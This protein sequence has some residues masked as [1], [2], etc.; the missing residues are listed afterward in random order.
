VISPGNGTSTVDDGAQSGARGV[1]VGLTSGNGFLA[2]EF[3]GELDLASVDPI[4]QRLLTIATSFLGVL[5]ID[6]GGVE[7][8]DSTALGL[9]V[10]MHGKNTQAG[11]MFVLVNVDR[12]VGRPIAI[13]GLDRLFTVH[14]ADDPAQDQSA[15]L[16]HHRIA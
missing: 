2:I 8:L 15:V 11:G 4:R 3:N 7:F 5:I 14:W 13:A 16:V 1:R 9:F 6:L 10:A 12:Q